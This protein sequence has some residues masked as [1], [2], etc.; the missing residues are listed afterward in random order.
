MRAISAIPLARPVRVKRM[1]IA[2][3]RVQQINEA[4]RAWEEAVPTEPGPEEDDDGPQVAGEAT[5]AMNDL[6]DLHQYS[7]TKGSSL[8]ELVQSFNPN[9]ARVYEQV[10]YHLEHQLKHEKKEC[11]YT[12]LQPLHMFVSGVG[13][14]CKSFLI[15]TVRALPSKLWGD[16]IR[17]TLCAVT[18]WTSSIQCRW[19]HNPSTAATAHCSRWQR[20][21]VLEA[22][23]RNF[24]DHAYV[25]V[26]AQTAHHRQ[27]V[28]GVHS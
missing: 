17:S 20:S 21:W 23:Q 22:G 14:T 16:E 25:F 3:E 1:L 26:Q 9:Q 24:K 11:H 10:K 13:G 19:S 7:D 12:D 8:E 27:S 4:R 18:H 6:V 2:I 28:Y 15:K 5:S